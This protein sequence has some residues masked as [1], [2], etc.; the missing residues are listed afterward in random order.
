MARRH[1]HVGTVRESLSY[2]VTTFPRCISPVLL[3][4][5]LGAAGPYLTFSLSYPFFSLVL[6]DRRRPRGEKRGKL[7]QRSKQLRKLTVKVR[8][9]I[10]KFHRSIISTYIRLDL[11]SYF[12]LSSCS[13]PLRNMPA[14]RQKGSTIL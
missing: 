4:L 2:F 14:T 13:K 9:K 11:L 3:P 5:F 7:P 6:S 1:W 12:L 10:M 8:P